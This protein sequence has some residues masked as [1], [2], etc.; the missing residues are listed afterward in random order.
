MK[1][2]FYVCFFTYAFSMLVWQIAQKKT[3]MELGYVQNTLVLHISSRT[4]VKTHLF[5]YINDVKSSP[6]QLTQSAVKPGVILLLFHPCPSTA[7]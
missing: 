1:D 5:N 7:W 2:F 3:Q 4:L 6:V